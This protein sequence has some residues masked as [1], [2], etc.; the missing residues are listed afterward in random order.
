MFLIIN[1][2]EE[3]LRKFSKNHEMNLSYL[4]KLIVN[5]DYF[6]KIRDFITSSSKYLE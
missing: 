2:N 4:A 6:G 3:K 5:L 1:K